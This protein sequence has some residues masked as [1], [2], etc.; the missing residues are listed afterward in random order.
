MPLPQAL[1]A[2]HLAQLEHPDAI[3]RQPPLQFNL[4]PPRLRIRQDAHDLA[5]DFEAVEEVGE[6]GEVGRGGVL[7]VDVEPDETLGM[8]GAA[9]CLGDV[10]GVDVGE[11]GADEGEGGVV[12]CVEE[13][14]AALVGVGVVDWREGFHGLGVGYGWVERHGCDWTCR[15]PT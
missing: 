12:V 13:G 4:L 6:V 1:E 11:A 8:D 15:L 10:E 3:I 9:E 5:V 2:R 14:G 7:A